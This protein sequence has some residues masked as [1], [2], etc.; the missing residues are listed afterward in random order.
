LRLEAA[1]WY[2]IAGTGPGTPLLTLHG[3][4]GASSRYLQPLAA[5]ADERPV[6]FY[7]QLGGG[8]SDRPDDVT[9]WTLERFV[10]ELAQVRA[11]LNLAR[12]HLYGSSWGTMLA[13][14]YALTQPP[15]LTSL[16]LSGPFLSGP[17]YIQDAQALKRDLPIALQEA[18]ER[19][20]AAEALDSPA[21]QAAVA[22]WMRQHVC[23]NATVLEGFLKD[24]GDPLT[25]ANSQIYNTMQGPSEFTITGNLKDVDLTGRLREIKAPTLLTCGRYDECTPAA[26][27]WYQSLLPDAE[28]VVF[29]NSAHLHSLEEPERYLQ[30]VR[31]FLHGVEGRGVVS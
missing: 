10:E 9:L 28:M 24:L 31:G 26:T 14:A 2:R 18:I 1:L 5:L 11:A 22:E 8:K 20:E 19:H 7:D 15:G 29:E 17:R 27:A 13:V 23:R 12:I 16:I 21:Y 30:T 25:G 4:P 3:G 6:I